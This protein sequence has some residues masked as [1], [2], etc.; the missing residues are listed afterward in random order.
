MRGES[1][2]LSDRKEKPARED[3]S[4]AVS[5]KEIAPWANPGGTM[6]GRGSGGRNKV[7]AAEHHRRGTWRKDRHARAV[8][9]FPA[10]PVAAAPPPPLP[11]ELL[12]GLQEP[13]R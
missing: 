4:R 9:P 11:G 8:V 1:S 3:F 5:K 13:G 6:G 2:G 12:E 10:P 7:T